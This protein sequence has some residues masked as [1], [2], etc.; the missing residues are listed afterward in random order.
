MCRSRIALLRALNPSVPIYGLFGGSKFERSVAKMLLDLEGLYVSTR[1]ERWNWQHSDLAVAAWY[2]EVGSRVPFD[3]A[4][5]I[6]WDLLL[7]APLQ[8]LYAHVPQDTVGLTALTP[9]SV[10]EHEWTWLRREESR[11]EWDTLLSRARADWGYNDV[12]H[13]CLGPGPCFPRAFLEAYAALGP[14]VL[15]NDELRLPL[16]AQ[17]LGFSLA[18][19]RL[20]GPWHGEREDPF[21]HFRDKEID[22]SAIRAEL[23]KHD[24]WR[25]FHPVRTRLDPQQILG[26]GDRDRRA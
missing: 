11:R 5:V 13:G 12:P 6:E 23:A 22:V 19:T 7:L 14:P 17:I 24:G 25:A 21:F 9:V 2:R 3:V 10:L 8:S 18:D 26:S 16:F 4:H 1:P 20:R 15:C